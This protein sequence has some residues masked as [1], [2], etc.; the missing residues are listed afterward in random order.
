MKGRI[1]LLS[2]LLLSGCQMTLDPPQQA[3]YRDVDGLAAAT[4]CD[5]PRALLAD[6]PER[7]T[8]GCAND[9]NLLQ[10]VERR[11]DLLRGRATGPT[12]AEP[13]GRAALDYLRGVRTDE[14]RDRQREQAAQVE[15]GAGR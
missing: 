6:Q 14:Q 4:A 3:G 15:T 2:A 9:A 12:L 5:R 1:P 11:E 8:P 10:M 13:V 7:L